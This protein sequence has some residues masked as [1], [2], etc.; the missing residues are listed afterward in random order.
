MKPNIII[1][2]DGYSSCGKSTLAR[3]LARRLKLIYVDSGAMYRA[4]TL[5]FLQ[6]KIPIPLPEQLDSVSYNYELTIK[7]IKINFKINYATGSS[8]ISINGKN[9]EKQIRSLE[10]SKNVSHVSAIKAVRE[11]LVAIQQELGQKGGIV[12]DGRD[13]GTTVFPH[14]DIKIFMTANTEVRAKRR[15]DE[16]TA[17]GIKTT[18]EEILKNIAER[19]HE[20]SHRKISPLRQ[21]PDAIVLDNTFL[22]EE[23]QVE[24]VLK[25]IKEKSLIST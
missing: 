6:N 2:I 4:V 11:K 22:N 23:E 17:R 21:A 9:V 10:V 7:W 1:A 18:F 5:F 13:I 20:D 12:M 15:Y 16:L 8:E 14:A 3:E 19:D 25:V 24:F